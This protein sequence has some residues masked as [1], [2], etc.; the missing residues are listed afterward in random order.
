MDYA[1]LKA[2]LLAALEKKS[3]IMTFD[4]ESI[5]DLCVEAVKQQ[6]EAEVSSKKR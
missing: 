4:R 6:M 2:D 5:A 1:K 3:S